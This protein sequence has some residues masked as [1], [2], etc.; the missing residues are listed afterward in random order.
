M[1]DLAEDFVEKSHEIGKRLDHLT[2]HISS[3]CF[4]TKE[5]IKMRLKWVTTDP[6]AQKQISMVKEESQRH[7]QDPSSPCKKFKK[8]TNKQL[9]TV[10]Q[11]QNLSTIMKK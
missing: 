2:A 4:R 3:Q 9:K 7:N 10:K 11:E 5:L 1:T 6:L 8:D